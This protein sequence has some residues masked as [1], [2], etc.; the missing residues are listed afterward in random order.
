[1][2]EREPTHEPPVS[3]DE[4]QSAE[5]LARA[6]EG[7]ATGPADLEAL[8]AAR[9]LQALA[10]PG[11]ELVRHR[12]RADLVA[13]A[14]A[15]RGARARRRYLVAAALA[16]AALLGGL[17]LR[18]PGGPSEPLL[19]EREA[20]ASRAVSAVSSGWTVDA[21]LSSHLGSAF[22]A[23]WRSRLQAQVTGQRASALAALET[24][25]TRPS[26]PSSARPGGT[27]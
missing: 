17:L 22:D 3:A 11:D 6:L 20:R 24:G 15:M 4:V 23:Q 7:G 26:S 19:A 10:A 12:Q 27:S 21:A 16:G 5:R 25:S 8:A 14:Q 9:L 13:R 18:G 1:M 2:S